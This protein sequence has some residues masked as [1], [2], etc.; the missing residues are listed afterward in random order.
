MRR[1]ILS[2]LALAVLAACQPATTELTDAQRAAIADTVTQLTDQLLSLTG[3]ADAWMDLF[4]T[5]QELRYVQNGVILSRDDLESEMTAFV[6]ACEE[7]SWAWDDVHVVVLGPDAA[8]VTATYHGAYTDTTGQTFTFDEIVVTYASARSDG[9]W[10]IV[11]AHEY[12][13][14][15]DSTFVI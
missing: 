15:P 9:T 6:G 11:Q 13:A 2:A 14:P 12:F 8:A 3:D 10:K 4:S 5:G 1:T 7:Q